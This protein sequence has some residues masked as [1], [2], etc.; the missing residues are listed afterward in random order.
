[1][2]ADAPLHR[3]P[4]LALSRAAAIA[5]AARA[6]CMGLLRGIAAPFRVMEGAVDRPVVGIDDSAD[7]GGWAVDRPFDTEN[8]DDDA[9]DNGGEGDEEAVEEEGAR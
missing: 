9:D 5:A 8:N 3:R 2:P 1:M 4:P 6:L 7:D